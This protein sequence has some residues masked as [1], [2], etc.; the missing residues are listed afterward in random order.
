MPGASPRRSGHGAPFPAECLR[1]Q[2]VPDR[3]RPGPLCG[4]LPKE[5][6]LEL[7]PLPR[8]PGSSR[9]HLSVSRTS[10]L[11]GITGSQAD[12]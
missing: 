6:N 11:E 5:E 8:L 10:D 9:Q 12:T 3:E 1:G 2:L 7:S 4:P